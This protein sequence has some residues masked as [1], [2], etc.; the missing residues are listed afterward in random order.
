MIYVFRAET[1]LRPLDAREGGRA[2]G[3]VQIASQFLPPRRHRVARHLWNDQVGHGRAAARIR[4]GIPRW[5]SCCRNTPASRT[6]ASIWT[7]P[8]FPESIL[9]IGDL[10]IFRYILEYMGRSLYMT[11]MFADL[12]IRRG[13]DGLAAGAGVLPHHRGRRLRPAHGRPGQGVWPRSR[14]EDRRSRI[15]SNI[16]IEKRSRMEDRIPTIASAPGPRRV[17]LR[18]AVARSDLVAD[19]TADQEV[20]PTGTSGP[21]SRGAIS[22]LTGRRTGRSTLRQTP[23]YNHPQLAMRDSPPE[24]PRCS[25]SPPSRPRS[26][27]RDLT[28][29]SSTIFAASTC[30]P[31]ACS[32]STRQSILS[33]RWFY[34]IPAQG[35]PRKLVHRI[36][37]GALDHLPGARADLSALAG[38]GSRR[39]AS[40]SAV[41]NAWRWNM[42]RATPIPTS[43]ASMP[44][45]S[46]WCAR[47]AWRSSRPATWCSC[48]R[49]AGTTTQWAM[50]LEAAKHT[51]LGLRRRL[52]LHRRARPARPAPCRETEVQQR[53]LDHFAQHRPGDR[54]SADRRRRPAQRRP[55]LRP[56]PRQRRRDPAR[57][58]SCSSTCG[59]SSI[60]PRRSTA[61]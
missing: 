23:A 36:E 53:I 51:P 47:S 55:A 30:W 59:P 21:P 33:R 44:A 15:G 25:T 22:S 17:D 46:S 50:H 42:C 3:R 57:A 58:I 16:E 29:G 38:T 49:R 14:M 40:W 13:T 43:R 48:S 45:P 9:W 18:S 60:S 27:N 34:F 8:T 5:C 28:A 24:E 19:R 26:C 41:P 4:I 10:H 32:A 11:V 2:L 54:P 39:R 37:P 20:H 35:E 7:S 1:F 56:G 52:R 12:L 6:A 61:T 31:A